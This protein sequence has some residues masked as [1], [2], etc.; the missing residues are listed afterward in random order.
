MLKHFNREKKRTLLK[1]SVSRLGSEYIM[2]NGE[3]TSK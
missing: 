2:V 3:N 1:V